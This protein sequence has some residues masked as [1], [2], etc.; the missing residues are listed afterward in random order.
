MADHNGRTGPTTAQRRLW[1]RR[2]AL[3]LHGSGKTSVAAAHEALRLKW[4]R[5]ADPDGVLPPEVRERRAGQLRRA[6]MIALSLAAA[7]A[8]RRKST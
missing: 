7:D 8:R 6:H 1:G 4:Q 5:L 2:G 3:I